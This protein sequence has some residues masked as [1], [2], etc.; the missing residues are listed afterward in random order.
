MH[1]SLNSESGRVAMEGKKISLALSY[2][3][4]SVII[5]HQSVPAFQVPKCKN[6]KQTSELQFCSLKNSKNR[7]Q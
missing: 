7:L 4:E 2:A 5:L 6:L 1:S 3:T